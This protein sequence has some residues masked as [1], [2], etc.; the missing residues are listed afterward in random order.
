MVRVSAVRGLS[1]LDEFAERL[2]EHTTPADARLN[3]TFADPGGDAQL[4][5]LAMG[6]SRSYGNMMVQKLR[7]RLGEQA[8]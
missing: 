5:A 7:L 4:V 3:Y 2:S 8:R 6:K 1:K